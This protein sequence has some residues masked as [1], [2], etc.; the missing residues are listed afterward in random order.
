MR[1]FPLFSLVPASTFLF[2]L[3]FPVYA[4]SSA[5]DWLLRINQSA[6]ELNYEGIFVYQRGTQLE[7]MR[8]VHRV[9]NGAVEERLVSLTGPTREVIRTDSEVRCYLPDQKSIVVEL[10]RANR[11]SFPAIIPDRLSDLK[12]NYALELG[13]PARVSG[14]SAQ[15]V[16]IRPRDDFR[17]GYQL[18]ADQATGLLLKADLLD[19]KGKVLEQFM[20]TQ[21]HIGGDIPAASLLP[22]TSEE[23]MRWYRDSEV[24]K[25][26]AA[27][28]WR[29]A[30]LPKGFKLTSTVVRKMPMSDRVVEQL[31]YSDG[32]AA[33]SVFLE[34]RADTATNHA[35]KQMGALNAVGR[36][37]EE[38]Y[39]TVVGEVPIKT[40]EL[41]SRS[42][43]SG[44]DR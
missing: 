9:N 10:R 11:K 36:V 21:I 7:T 40:I 20:F 31:V 17:Y 16:L 34:K 18:W 23:G 24:P 2:F 19:D 43:V 28:N 12:H 29:V 3:S 13:K 1:P 6:R 8:I 35:P 32:L 38:H 26:A 27:H 22:Q 42:L 41:I 33:V 39:A 37:L 44:K 4:A 5:H 30:Q 25:P 14:R 15:R